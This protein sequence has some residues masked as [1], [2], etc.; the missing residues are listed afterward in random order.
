M[1]ENHD[2]ELPLTCTTCPNPIDFSCEPLKDQAE[3][4]VVAWCAPCQHCI[5]CPTCAGDYNTSYLSRVLSTKGKHPKDQC[6]MCHGEQKEVGGVTLVQAVVKP[7][8]SNHRVDALVHE[9]QL[10]EKLTEAN[11]H[12]RPYKSIVFS[13]WSKPLVLVTQQLEL[14]GIKHVLM[15]GGS[16]HKKRKAILDTFNNDPSVHVLVYTTGVAGHGLDLPIADTIFLMDPLCN[17][18]TERQCAQRINRIGQDRPM[19]LVRYIM[20]NTI[21]EDVQEVQRRKKRVQ[22]FIQS[23]GDAS[24]TGMTLAELQEVFGRD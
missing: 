3:G 10:R 18:A 23:T 6:S 20:A 15:T 17:P 13:Q 21:E 2:N 14:H 12:E 11:P 22:D 24:A 8:R 7:L 5:L 4:D 16:S 1:A 19:R 9:L